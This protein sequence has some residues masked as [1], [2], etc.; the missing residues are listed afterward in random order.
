VVVATDGPSAS[1]LLNGLVSDPG[2][3][4]VAAC[5]YSLPSLP[6]GDGF[7]MLDGLSDGPVRNLAPIS[8]VQP[9]YAPAGRSLIVA[10]VPGPA[11]SQPDLPARVSAQVSEWLNVAPSELDLLRCDV[12]AHGQPLQTPPLAVRRRVDL[13]NG[14]FV[15]GDHRDTASLQGAMFSGERTASAVLAHVG[16]RP[17]SR[18]HV[19]GAVLQTP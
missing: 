14:V 18:A 13:G 5:W 9:S 15:C 6:A 10:A 8:E 4:P 1:H 3:R 17:S 11:A 2:S 12:I 16:G 19:N 7:L